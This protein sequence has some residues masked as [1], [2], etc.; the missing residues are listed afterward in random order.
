MALLGGD[1]R[2]LDGDPDIVGQDTAAV[3]QRCVPRSVI[4]GGAAHELDREP[5]ARTAAITPVDDVTR[6]TG[7]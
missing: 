6:K 2:E 1:E 5:E 4:A 3:W 7:L